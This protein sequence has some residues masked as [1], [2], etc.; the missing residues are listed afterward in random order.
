M[1]FHNATR[2][3]VLAERGVV[4]R[5]AVSRTVGLMFR[6][7]FEE[8]EGLHIIPCDGIHMM[9][10]FF[11]IDVAFLDVGS[12]VVRTKANVTPFMGLAMGG[13]EAHSVLELPQ[14]TLARTGTREGDQ[15]LFEGSATL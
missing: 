10:V 9:F 7:T 2:N 12:V 6:R 5:H 8:G 11:P 4:C 15:I 1:K 14:G 13:P 3:V